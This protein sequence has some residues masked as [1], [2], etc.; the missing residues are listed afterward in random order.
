M[1]IKLYNDNPNPKQVRYVADF[2]RDGGIVIYPTDTIYAIGCSV[3]NAKGIA[4]ISKLKGFTAKNFD[5]SLICHDL[6]QLSQYTK[7]LPQHV[8]KLMKRNLPGPFTF[9]LEAGSN[10]PKLFGDRKKSIGI[11][12]PEN[13]II[14]EIAKELDNPIMSTSIHDPDEVI[15]YSTDPELIHDR[16]EQIAG[17][18][19]DG[20]YGNKIPSTIVDCTKGE[21][22]ILRQG[23]GILK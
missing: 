14:R 6:S 20:G 19:V 11:R 13:N 8:F 5:F 15:E 21:P 3:F 2:L 4:A 12:V 7:P 16:Y 17:I 1:I 9:I 10:T 23:L 18:V 22:V